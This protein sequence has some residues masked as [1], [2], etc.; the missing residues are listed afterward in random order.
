MAITTCR[1]IPAF[2]STRPYDIFSPAVNPGGPSC[3]QAVRGAAISVL[4]PSETFKHRSFSIMKRSLLIALAVVL[5]VVG[6]GSAAV[7]GGGLATPTPTSTPTF[8]ALPEPSPVD[9]VVSDPTTVPAPA[10]TPTVVPTVEPTVSETSSPASEAPESADGQIAQVQQVLAQQGYYGG[11]IDGTVGSATASAV[12]AFQKVHGLVAD[13]VIGPN[14]IAATADPIAPTLRGGAADRIEVD[15]DKQVLFVVSGGNLER[16]LPISSGSGSTYDNPSGG[17][18]T[19]L[20]PVG[21]FK[22]ERRIEGVREA[23]LGTLYDPMYFYSGWAIHGSNS[24]PAYP[25][26]HGCIRVT[27]A[28][29]K[30]L[31]DRAPV[32]MNV[33][34]FGNTNA[35]S[36][37]AGESAGTTQPA[38]DTEA[39]T[40]DDGIQNEDPAPAPTAPPAAAVPTP[41]PPPPPTVQP[42]PSQT[43]TPPASPT[44]PSATT[45]APAP[46]APT[47]PIPPPEPN[48]PTPVPTT[49]P[50][51]Q[52]PGPPPEPQAVG[53]AVAPGS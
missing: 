16:I 28:D 52:A 20:T 47:T 21:S 15:L 26:S 48:D 22:V 19:S 44:E 10:A 8:V 7:I 1:Q 40:P 29:A 39:T 13:G 27:R 23:P 4:F 53:P 43:Q 6:I 41:P 50:T 30:W 24:V 31:F 34:I 45:P 32:G 17:T 36:P 18:A 35:F 2:R 42:Q 3:V 14:T 37:A 38:G 11:S 33:E 9:V 25:A 12:M 5:A 49:A 46:P 51:T